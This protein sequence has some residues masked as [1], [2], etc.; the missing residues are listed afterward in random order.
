MDINTEKIVISC[1]VD[2]QISDGVVDGGVRCVLARLGASRLQDR[3]GGILGNALNDVKSENH[4]DSSLLLIVLGTEGEMGIGCSSCGYRD[5][6]G[7]SS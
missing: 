4:Q 3:R 5:Y 2:T 6:K 1:A 7:L